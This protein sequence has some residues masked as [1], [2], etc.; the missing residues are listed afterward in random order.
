MR[1]GNGQSVLVRLGGEFERWEPGIVIQIRGDQKGPDEE[2]TYVVDMG[3]FTW[4]FAAEDMQ[5]N[6]DEE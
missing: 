6:D 5:A 3:G 1:Y 2:L 4:R